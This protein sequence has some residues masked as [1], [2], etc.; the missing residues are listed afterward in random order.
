[1]EELEDLISRYN[2]LV[3]AEKRQVTYR[4]IFTVVT[5]GLSLVS[6]LLAGPIAS[7]PFSLAATSSG[8]EL[9]RFATLEKSSVVSAGETAPAVMF[10][11]V[12][13]EV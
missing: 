3:A 5:A 9:V 13:S 8:L 6:A 11:E 2:T 7:I 1:M 12:E 10:H 4:L